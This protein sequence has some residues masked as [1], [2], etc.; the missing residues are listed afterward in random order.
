MSEIRTKFIYI[1][2]CLYFLIIVS[3]LFYLQVLIN[4]DFKREIESQTERRVPIAAQRGEIFARDGYPLAQNKNGYVLNFDKNLEKDKKSLS[5]EQI[6]KLTEILTRDKQI[7]NEIKNPENIRERKNRVEKYIKDIFS[8]KKVKAGVIY[9]KLTEET[10]TTI[11]KLKIPELF[12]TTETLRNYTE[13]SMSA[14]ILGFLGRDEQDNLKGYFGLEGYYD[15][16]LKGIDGFK[17]YDRDPFGNPI[18]LNLYEKKDAID[19]RSLITSIDRGAQKIVE[20]WLLW[21]VKTYQAKAGSAILYNP[22]DGEILAL[23]NTPSFD[24]NKYYFFPDVAKKNISISDEYEPGSIMK[25]LIMSAALNEKLVTP[26][27]RCPKCS[28]PREVSGYLVRT[29]DDQYSPGLTMKEVLQRSDNTGMTWVGE[30]LGKKRI[31]NYFKRL[32]FGQKTQVDLEGEANG[33]VKQEQDIYDIDQATM[34]FGQGISVTS[35]QMVK[36]YGALIT[37]HTVKPHVVTVLSGDQRKDNIETIANE[38]VYSKVVTQQIT[39][40]L[41][42]VTEKSPLHFAVDNFTPQL[43]RYHIAAKSGTAQIPIGGEY[44]KDKT[45]GTV[46]GFAPA[47]SP[48][49]ILFVKLD[50][51]QANIW[52]ANTAGPTFVNILKDLFLYYNIPPQ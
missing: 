46:I 12:F 20:K 24:P 39:D 35:L 42:S 11:E 40:I 16:E 36:A 30:L 6:K 3:R 2:F 21:G 17:I 13:S 44:V 34:T 48:K 37:G 10:K 25:P 5:P 1:I 41:V 15:L 19:G 32:G 18:L 50:E 33:F 45:V 51:A 31:L 29:F 43:K 9:K 27:T 28:G 23:A 22:Y 14:H 8:N 52:G 38:N 7:F 26:D 47:Y 49:F 4:S